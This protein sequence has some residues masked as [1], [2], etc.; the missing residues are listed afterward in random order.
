LRQ[1][2]STVSKK[3]ETATLELLDTQGLP[4]NAVPNHKAQAV[5]QRAVPVVVGNGIH[6]EQRVAKVVC[7]GCPAERTLLLPK[8]VAVLGP[9]P[10]LCKNCTGSRSMLD[11][12]TKQEIAETPVAR[13]LDRER[14]GGYLEYTN[15][16]FAWINGAA[17][18]RREEDTKRKFCKRNGFTPEQWHAR[19]DA[20]GWFCADCRRELTP[21]TAVRWCADGSRALDKTIPLC[22][23]C[24]CKRVG[25][26]GTPAPSTPL[27][28][29]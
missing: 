8:D 4:D 26:L 14:A 20:L 10:F 21:E 15:G 25:L 29:A 5:A 17:V 2:C 12:M 19:V 28:A 16:E 18:R 22:R 7:K 23:A 27:S 24:Q 13:G 11:G 1:L 6:E 3:S 9:I